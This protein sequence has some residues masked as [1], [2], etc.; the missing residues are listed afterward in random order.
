IVAAIDKGKDH[1]K[2]SLQR[3]G[4]SGM[5]SEV[6]RRNLQG[7]SAS[8]GSGLDTDGNLIVQH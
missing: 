5:S 1:M 7:G 3:D 8:N 6:A 2:T 4:A